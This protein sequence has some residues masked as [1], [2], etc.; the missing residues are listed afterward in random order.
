ME[1]GPFLSSLSLPPS[2]PPLPLPLP[3]PSTPVTIPSLPPSLRFLPSSASPFSLPQRPLVPPT[4][5]SPSFF[6][7]SIALLY[8]PSNHGPLL[9]PSFTSLFSF[10]PLSC[11][12]LLHHL[13]SYLPFP[14]SVS[15][16]TTSALPPTLPSSPSS[17]VP[18]F[19]PS[20]H[21]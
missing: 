18:S 11:H 14:L 12:S 15:P 5:V 4:F 17:A 9:S 8:L 16:A 1:V 10:P 20:S 3:L 19:L 13:H 21:W 7:L 6:S 2:S